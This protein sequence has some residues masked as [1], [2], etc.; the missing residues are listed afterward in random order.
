M[1]P[2][3]SV[4]A[5]TVLSGAGLG[6]LAL[7]PL[8]DLGAAYAGWPALA[9]R[10]VLAVAAA[11]AVALVLAGLCSSTL[12]LANP[13]N[14]WRSATRFRTSW[15]SREASF[16]LL[17]VPVAVVFIAAPALDVRPRRMCGWAAAT[18][19]L[20]WTVL[21]CTA[22]ICA[23]LKPIRQWHTARVP[24]AY[25]VL[26]HASGA[27]IVEAVVRPAGGATWIASAGVALLVASWLVNEEYRR[28]ARSGEGALTIEDAIGVAH[29][30]GPPGAQRPGSVMAARLLDGSHSRGTFLTREF[31]GP[32]P[33][34]QDAGAG[35]V[36]RRFGRRAGRVAGRRSR[37][38]AGRR[39]RRRFLPCRP[40]RGA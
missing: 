27:L 21:A 4:I 16:A 23:R 7:V 25:P 12:H 9:S 2:A 10:R 13:R 35:A 24:L 34:A 37:R 31:V 17:L 22:M 8:G 26:A 38:S 14:A 40:R 15:L 19:L 33:D 1:L 5:F 32:D 36:P 20:A 39:R 6:A 11:T 3:P 29:G 28:H 18:L 30:V